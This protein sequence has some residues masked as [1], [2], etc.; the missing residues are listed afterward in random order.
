MNE[1]VKETIIDE[2]AENAPVEEAV[3]AVANVAKSGRLEVL[4]KV[5]VR[6]AIGTC[7]ALTCYGL[8]KGGKYVY[9][10]LAKKN[11]QDEDEF[12]T[13][14]FD[15]ELTEAEVE[16]IQEEVVDEVQEKPKKNKKEDK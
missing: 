8:Y 12:E 14:Y 10:K 11:V 4:K 9:G 6:T 2:V 16:T 3:E 13:E 5:G 7:V 1:Q 15:D